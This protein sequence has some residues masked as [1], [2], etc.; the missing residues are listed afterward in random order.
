MSDFSP[1]RDSYRDSYQDELASAYLD[2]DVTIEE[3]AVVESDPG[4]LARVEQLRSVRAALAE[5]VVPPTAAQRDAAI[6]AALGASN[7]VDLNAAR[8]QRRLRIASIAAAVVL[9]LGAAG[10]FIRAADDSDTT[11]F[12]AAAGSIDSSTTGPAAEKTAEAAGQTAADAAAG[13]GVDELQLSRLGL[14]SFADR[15]SLA[16]AVRGETN[17]FAQRSSSRTPAPSA[18][19]ADAT[20]SPPTTT[21]P[22]CLVPPPANSTG[23]IYAATAV[24][25]GREVQVDVFTLTD[26]SFLLVVTDT[27]SCT[28][29]FT[30]PV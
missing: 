14:G 25:Q 22:T 15:S 12:T 13:A 6:A 16:A 5:P 27:A 7:V 20:P 1:D 29:D 10:F 19:G 26:G 4:L 18:G 28:Q 11:T 21:A 23:Q 9:V 17:A 24:L 2:D 30:Q 3:R 8:G